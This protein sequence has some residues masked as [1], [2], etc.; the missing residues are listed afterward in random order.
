MTASPARILSPAFLTAAVANFLFFTNLSAFFLLPLHVQRLGA[1]ETQ[2]GL[3]MGTYSAVAI[4]CPPLVGAWVDRVGRRPFLLAG[5]ALA[6]TASLGF[7]AAP[8]TLALFPVWRALQGVAYAAYFV[9]NFALAVDLVPPDRRGQAIGI[10]GISGLMSAAVGPA[11]GE[12]VARAFGFPVFFAAAAAVGGA[13]LVVSARLEEP[14]GERRAA[15]VAL[16]RLIRGVVRAPR[17]PLALAFAFG[18]GIGAIFTFLPTHAAALGVERIGLFAVAYSLAALA[19]RALGGRLIDTLGRRP[20]IIPALALQAG[21]A[22]LLAGLGPLVTGAGLSAVPLLA[23][24]GVV[25]GVAHGFLYPALTALV[26]DR[27]ADAAR[28]QI[29]GVFSAFVLTGNATGAMGFGWL[30]H[31]LGYGAMFALLAALLGGA[32]ALAFRLER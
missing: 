19:V 30:A 3:I 5:A 6:A 32:S 25:A 28:G 10:F 21:A 15:P 20:V 27:T 11:L 13:A 17:V 8:D 22:A 12:S 2:L 16:G 9:A 4:V 7:A 26:I 23:L 31:A 24:T 14:P 29:L 1:T 18:L